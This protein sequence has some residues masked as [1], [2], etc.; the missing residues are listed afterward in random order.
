MKAERLRRKWTQT[1]LAARCGLST[2]DVSRI[3]TGRLRPYPVQV[4]RIAR[5]LRLS[6][7]QLFVDAAGPER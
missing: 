3:E 2:S 1:E 4:S 6:R 5:A 7:V